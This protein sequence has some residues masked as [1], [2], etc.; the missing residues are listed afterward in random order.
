[1]LSAKVAVILSRGK[2]VKFESTAA[3]HWI[4]KI[5]QSVNDIGFIMVHG[6]NEDHIAP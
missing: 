3:E 4:F 2:W 1:M 5:Q 6:L